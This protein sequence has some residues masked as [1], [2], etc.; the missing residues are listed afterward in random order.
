MVKA[1]F[2]LS[3]FAIFLFVFLILVMVNI[4]VFQTDFEAHEIQMANIK[5]IESQL[6]ELSKVLRLLWYFMHETLICLARFRVFSE[7]RFI[8]VG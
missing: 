8:R 4:H 6:I 1:H 2:S 3:D 5:A 7:L